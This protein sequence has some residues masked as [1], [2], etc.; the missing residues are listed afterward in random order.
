MTTFGNFLTDI[1]Y[2][3]GDP[4]ESTWSRTLEVWTWLEEAIREFPIKRPMT[5]DLSD[6]TYLHKI[7]L[8]TDFF[9][10]VSVEWPIDQNPPSFCERRDRLEDDFY[11]G[12]YYDV[13]R[14]YET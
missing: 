13:E 9:S 5:D 14:D 2:A 8:P 1:M 4:T 12:Y 10:I 6:N 3:L 11:D 7:T